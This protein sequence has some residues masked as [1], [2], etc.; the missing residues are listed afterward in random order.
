MSTHGKIGSFNPT[1]ETWSSYSERLQY[2]FEANEIRDAKKHPTFLS[3][4]GPSTF[5]LLSSLAQPKSLRDHSFTEL[6][7]LLDKHY[8][9]APSPIVQRFTFNTRLRR[10]DESIAEFVAELKSIARHCKFGNVLNDMLRD[11]LVCGVNDT[12]IQR[13]LLQEPNLTYEKAL[14]IAQGIE[15]A[16]KNAQ[17]LHLQPT[18]TTVQH[19]QQRNRPRLQRS[20]IRSYHPPSSTQPCYRCGEQHLQ[21]QCRFRTSICRS[22][23]KQVIVTPCLAGVYTN[24]TR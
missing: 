23:G 21:T 16:A 18:A 15:A 20:A 1:N 5:Q 9:P 13:S 2:Y 11:R 24:Y 17:Q 10:S 12:R 22:C 4:C 3:I 8:D 7:E 14:E 19:L 6:T